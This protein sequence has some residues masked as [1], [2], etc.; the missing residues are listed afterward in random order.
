MEVLEQLRSDMDDA[1]REAQM[2]GENET[3]ACLVILDEFIGEHEVVEVDAYAA[4]EKCGSR[5]RFYDRDISTPTWG[6]L[7]T[8]IVPRKRKPEPRITDHTLTERMAVLE[9]EVKHRCGNLG[10]RVNALEFKADRPLLA[11]AEK[12]VAL[13]AP[14]GDYVK[15]VVDDLRVAVDALTAVIKEERER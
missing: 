12:V 13:A 4:S 10:R 1:G 2:T 3:L 15:V 5:P 8:I 7:Q 14:E 11:A 6:E 9:D